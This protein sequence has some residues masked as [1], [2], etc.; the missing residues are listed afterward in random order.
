MRCVTLP[1]RV[2]VVQKQQPRSNSAEAERMQEGPVF[3]A[4]A[5]ADAEQGWSAHESW[6]AIRRCCRGRL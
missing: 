5:T 3:G 1:L 2:E 4:E 6:T